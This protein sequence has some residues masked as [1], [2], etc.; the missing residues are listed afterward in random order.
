[1]TVLHNPRLTEP[2][3]VEP[4]IRRAYCSSGTSTDFD[5]WG[6]SWNQSPTDTQGR[7]YLV[8]GKVKLTF[9]PTTKRQGFDGYNLN[10]EID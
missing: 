8:P 5:I 7:L 3:D 6:R 10:E 4:W 1:M 2:V 9:R